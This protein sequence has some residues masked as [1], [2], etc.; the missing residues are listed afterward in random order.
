[1]K[2]C[3]QEYWVFKGLSANL[4]SG[5]ICVC[6]QSYPT[7]HDP[8]DCSPPGSSLHGILQ[9]RIMEWAAISFSREP[10]RPKDQTRI[11]C[12]SCNGR[13]FTNWATREQSFIKQIFNHHLQYGRSIFLQSLAS[14]G[15]HRKFSKIGQRR[16]IAPEINKGE[17]DGMV[18]KCLLDKWTF[19]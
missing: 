13:F 9:A 4:I 10:S 7:L 1:M 5:I 2:I 15:G 11:S 3:F 17:S 14:S 18:K 19:H 16:I 12:V 8:M 6:A